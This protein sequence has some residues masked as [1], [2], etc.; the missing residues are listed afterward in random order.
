[1]KKQTWYECSK[2]EKD[3]GVKENLLT[4][5]ITSILM[6]PFDLAALHWAKKLN[7]TPREISQAITPDIWEQAEEVIKQSPI[8]PKAAELVNIAKQQ[9]AEILNDKTQTTTQPTNQPVADISKW[10]SDIEIVAKTLFG[11]ARGEG[12]MGL[13]G[14]ASVIWTRAGGDISKLKD[15]CLK[16]KQFSCWNDGTVVVNQKDKRA[17]ASYKL[18]VTIAESMFRKTFEPAITADHYYS[19]QGKNKVKNKPAW[20]DPAKEVKYKDYKGDHKFFDL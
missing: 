8:D 11:E 14:V 7:R 17:V 9:G 12:E 10:K 4:I 13:K 15:V 1:M 18:C 5:A 6:L 19:Y 3:A 2:M 16:P 20:H